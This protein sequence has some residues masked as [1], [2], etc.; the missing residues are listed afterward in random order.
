MRGREIEVSSTYP[1]YSSILFRNQ[2][3]LLTFAIKQKNL[4]QYLKQFNVAGLHIYHAHIEVFFFPQVI[5]ILLCSSFTDNKY[6]RDYESYQKYKFL[7]TS[8]KSTW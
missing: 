3:S 7:I 8:F 1:V 4:Q 5:K 6:N 2:Q